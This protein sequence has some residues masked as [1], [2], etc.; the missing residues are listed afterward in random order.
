[1]VT[2]IEYQAFVKSIFL[3]EPD[4]KYNMLRAGLELAEEFMELYAL[5]YIDADMPNDAYAEL[6][7]L[8]L[9]ELGDIYFWLT[10]LSLDLNFELNASFISPIPD[11]YFTEPIELSAQLAGAIKRVYRDNN[12]AKLQEIPILANNILG[13]LLLVY[14]CTEADLMETNYAKL[15]KRLKNNT[16]Q[17][18]GDNR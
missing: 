6:A 11:A 18:E 2:K 7:Q 17:G 13:S 3:P 14:V 4:S 15:S 16:I 10:W 1:M 9:K 5:E 12:L 8:E